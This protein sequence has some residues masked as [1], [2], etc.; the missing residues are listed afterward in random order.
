MKK[1]LQN[2]R[3]QTVRNLNSLLR[4][5]KEN[6]RF[7]SE[8]K[9]SQF[10]NKNLVRL[11]TEYKKETN[12]YVGYSI[13]MEFI[14]NE[15]KKTIEELKK[16]MPLLIEANKNNEIGR[17]LDRMQFGR[18]AAA[19][20]QSDEEMKKT[21]TAG[22]GSPFKAMVMDRPRTNYLSRPFSLEEQL[23]G[24]EDPQQ[25]IDIVSETIGKV[26]GFVRAFINLFGDEENVTKLKDLVSGKKKQGLF[27]RLVSRGP[28]S[29]L[30]SMVKKAFSDL[31]EFDA[32]IFAKELKEKPDI[33]DINKKIES[34]VFS[35]AS[36]IPKLD[37]EY[38]SKVKLGLGSR[39]ASL[40]TSPNPSGAGGLFGRAPLRE[41]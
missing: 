8:N 17:Y 24:D 40:L 6:T 25:L 35:I 33:I 4:E 5:M 12:K 37:K 31:P 10:A 9:N 16:V 28:D 29:E 26:T 15:S 41:E 38:R 20:F 36:S 32:G 39:I 19:I 22:K 14:D 21:S 30:I 34:E 18:A 7:I 27:S 3:K 23:Q 11:L 13:L 1:L 2:G